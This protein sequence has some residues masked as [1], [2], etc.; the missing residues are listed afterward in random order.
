MGSQSHEF[1]SGGPQDTLT[2]PYNKDSGDD[3]DRDGLDCGGHIPV[4]S[5]NTGH[6]A[7]RFLYIFP[8]TPSKVLRELR[9]REVKDLAR[10]HIA[11]T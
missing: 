10:G 3:G 5:P 2:T 1:G 9:F 8:S 6:R 4:W 7:K 11:W